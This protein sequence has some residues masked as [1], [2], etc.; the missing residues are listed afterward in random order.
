MTA[1]SARA[2]S[3]ADLRIRPAGPADLDAIDAIERL[4]FQ[5][6]RFARRNLGRLLKSASVCVLIATA[7]ARP[8]GYA[9]L[10]FRKG[11]TR[12]RLYSIAVD[13]QARGRGVADALV[14]AAAA[15]ALRRGA[16]RIRLEM[17]PSNK[18]AQRLYER[19]GFTVF[20]RKPGYYEDGED[21]VRMER[22][23]SRMKAGGRG[24]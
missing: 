10:L 15:C 9:A 8:A 5:G 17:R 1:P 18:A 3:G 4:S 7:G 11:S 19:A 21:A 16:D 13:P 2:K 24:A 12:A 6:D 22:R 23:L 20:D 14:S